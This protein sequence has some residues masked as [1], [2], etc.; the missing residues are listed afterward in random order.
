MIQNPLPGHWEKIERL[1][2]EEFVDS[3]TKVNDGV[4]QIGF[5]AH[6]V[7]PTDELA[8]LVQSIASDLQLLTPHIRRLY[9]KLPQIWFP[10]DKVI[11]HCGVHSLTWSDIVIQCAEHVCVNSKYGDAFKAGKFIWKLEY[12]A[13]LILPHLELEFEFL[14][15]QFNN[16]KEPKL[17]GSTVDQDR[18]KFYEAEKKNNSRLRYKNAADLWNK[19]ELDVC[20][21]G[22]FRQSCYRAR[23]RN[24]T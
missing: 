24:K 13:S 4:N 3:I 12:D 7:E 14:E 21:E 17:T 11:S 6:T 18:L 8:A 19:K 20:D 23:K 15:C 10:R 22:S 2:V 1:A 5:W 16:K 9:H